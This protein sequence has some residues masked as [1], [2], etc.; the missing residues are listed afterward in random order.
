MYEYKIEIFPVEQKMKDELSDEFYK[1]CTV[2]SKQVLIN[3]D[4]VQKIPKNIVD[5]EFF[6]SFCFRKDMKSKKIVIFSFKSII[7]YLYEIYKSKNS[8][9]PLFLSQIEDYIE[10]HKKSGLKHLAL[11]Y[12]DESF[13]WFLNIDLI[14]NEDNQILF[15]E[16][17]KTII[18]ILVCFNP[19]YLRIDSHFIYY[20]IKQTIESAIENINIMENPIFILPL[21]NQKQSLDKLKLFSNNFLF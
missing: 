5:D 9:N 6:C 21:I 12:D 4:M 20:S 11:D 19:S 10:I 8:E 16:L 18:E 3:H 1:N 14:G 17:E 2:C 7:A 15:R 13:N